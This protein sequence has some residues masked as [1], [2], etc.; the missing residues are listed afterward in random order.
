MSADI[1]L[2]FAFALSLL[3]VFAG[4]TASV[5]GFGIGS[6]LTPFLALRLGTDVAI[7]VVVLPHLAGGLMRGWR[8]RHSIDRSVLLRFG[9]LSAAGGL[10]GAFFFARLAPEFLTRVLGL[11]L[12]L[13]ASASLAG[14]TERWKPRGILVWLLGLLSGFFGGVAGNQG[15][16]RAAGLT[17]F[18]LTQVEFVATSTA[19]GVFID[20]ARTPVYAYSAGSEILD[21]WALTGMLS[22][23][24]M[25]GTFAGERLLLG[26]SARSFRTLVSV[27][28]GILGLWFLL[29]PN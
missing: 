18:G 29:G 10:L 23:G 7:A 24:V 2:W 8:L 3:A 25:L 9:T 26:L 28:I 4:A 19:I 11:L 17:A 13:A 16:M 15:G 1:P 14:W 27:A 20:L 5:V 12:L 6:L 21:L 22:A